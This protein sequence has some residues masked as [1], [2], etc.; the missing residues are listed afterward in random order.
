MTTTARTWESDTGAGRPSSAPG[1][2]RSPSTTTTTQASPLRR[3]IS[4]LWFGSRPPMSGARPRRAATAGPCGSA[5][6]PLPATAG[7]DSQRT[8]AH[9]AVAKFREFALLRAKQRR[10]GIQTQTHQDNA[11]SPVMG[12]RFSFLFLIVKLQF[13]IAPAFTFSSC[14]TSLTR[15][16]SSRL[17]FRMKCSLFAPH[18]L[19]VFARFICRKWLGRGFERF[20][21]CRSA[22][23]R[24]PGSS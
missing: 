9:P 20:A 24:W 1:T 11:P 23:S 16:R 10:R 17:M 3:G 19:P 6:T 22:A 15:R 12:T 4:P 18:P 13:Y 8:S 5:S 2:T 21:G 14:F 7:A